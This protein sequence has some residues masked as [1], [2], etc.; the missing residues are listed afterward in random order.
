MAQIHQTVIL[1]LRWLFDSWSYTRMCQDQT[2]FAKEARITP[3]CV[4]SN[5]RAGRHNDRGFS[6]FP[7][8]SGT[9]S[10]SAPPGYHVWHGWNMLSVLRSMSTI[11]VFSSSAH[12]LRLAMHTIVLVLYLSGRASVMQVFFWMQVHMLAHLQTKALLY[13]TLHQPACELEGHS[14]ALPQ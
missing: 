5:S 1:Q 4:S 6:I 3:K 9:S 10:Y 7:Q 2:V 14:S 13:A 8:K 12:D 11:R